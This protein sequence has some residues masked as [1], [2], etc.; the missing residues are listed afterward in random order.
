MKIHVTTKKSVYSKQNFFL[1]KF[2]KQL[3]VIIPRVEKI[4]KLPSLT[5]SMSPSYLTGLAFWVWQTH[6]ARQSIMFLISYKN[7]MTGLSNDTAPTIN[8]TKL[9]L[10]SRKI[11]IAYSVRKLYIT[12]Y[13]LSFDIRVKIITSV[14]I[15]Q[16]ISVQ[17][18]IQI[19][20]GLRDFN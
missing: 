17:N 3:Y 9:L 15:I 16:T 18:L 14:K 19:K 8:R 4:S 20:H 6:V 2:S 5:A 11:K 1:S 10:F 7:K 12:I 13:N